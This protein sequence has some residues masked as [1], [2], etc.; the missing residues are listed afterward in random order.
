MAQTDS[1]QPA[2]PGASSATANTTPTE[3]KTTNYKGVLVDMS[4]ASHT[5]GAAAT[6]ESPGGA[7]ADS[8]KA[9]SANRS[10]SDSGPNCP[11][12]ASSTALGMKLDDA[13]RSASIW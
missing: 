1:Q 10:A 5:A 7:A 4:C 8:E 13:R 2:K 12:S 9:N 6:S 3:M 11:V